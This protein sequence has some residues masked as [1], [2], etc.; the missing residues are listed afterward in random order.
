MK[1]AMCVRWENSCIYMFKLL[2]CQNE[3]LR[4]A[5]TLGQYTVHECIIKHTHTHTHTFN[6]T[7]VR[8]AD[9]YTGASR[10]HT[11]SCMDPHRVS[12]TLH[13]QDLNSMT[14]A[15]NICNFSQVEPSTCRPHIVSDPSQ[16]RLFHN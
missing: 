13:T 9:R 15:A 2:F 5:F 11:Q 12:E 10:T 14:T 1:S 16:V 6:P 7:R 4:L 8:T 3:M